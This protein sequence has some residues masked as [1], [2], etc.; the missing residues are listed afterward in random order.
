MQA[1]NNNIQ[2]FIGSPKTVFVVPVY[3]RNYDWQEENCR[4]IFADIVNVVQSGH[5]HFLGTVCFKASNSHEREIIDGQQRLTSIFLLL[6]AIHDSDFD[7][8]I[9]SEINDLYLYNKGHGIDSEF[10][11][12]KLHL[13]KRDNEIYRVILGSSGGEIDSK[14]TITQRQASVYNNYQLFCELLKEY[15]DNGGSAGDIL[16]ALRKLTFVE[17]EIQDENPQEIFES[18]NSTGLDLTNVDLL[19]NYILMQFPH[20]VQKALYEDYWSRIEDLVGSENMVCFFVDYLIFKKRSDAL[21]LNGRRSHIT[22]K[23]LYAAFKEYYAS[24]ASD[25]VYDNTRRCFEDMNNSAELYRNFI[26]SSEINLE[27]ESPLRK[28][29]YFLLVA[30]ESTKCRSLLLF[31]LDLRKRDKI[32]DVQLLDAI[33]GVASL[34]FRAKVCKAQGLNRQ[35]SGNV[36]LRLDDIQ[37]YDAFTDA[38]WR[39]MTAGKGSYAFPS[40]AEFREA[41]R[42]KD[43]YQVLRSKGTKYLLYM[44]ETR[45]PHPKGLATFDSESMTIEHIMPQKLSQEWKTYLSPLSVE[46]HEENLHRLGNLS[47]TDYNGEM[48]NK[49]FEEKKQI[50]RDSKY[51][52]TVHICD[53]E[54]WQI[55]EINDRSK[56]LADIALKIWQLPDEF[57]RN[58]AVSDSLHRL[59]EDGGQFTHTK[60]STLYMDDS[61]YKIDRWCKFLPTICKHLDNEDHGALVA[62]AKSGKISGFGIQDEDH[63]YSENESFEHISENIYI[64]AFMSAINTLET[65][66]KITR[67]FDKQAET[68]YAENVMFSIK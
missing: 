9:R 42:E 51:Y 67:E 6:K 38:Y 68:D 39:A 41:L 10:L 24:F 36:M 31:L 54:N 34:T 43:L 55:E 47:L 60:P 18:L 66:L 61:E 4:R 14:L 63:N 2:E 56:K 45:S 40:D 25:D 28:K 52:F 11:R 65:A 44:I 48:S 46:K 59:G 33:D 29:L 5:E 30:N 26:F 20:N 23:S 35:F 15:V 19:R 32:T 22:E 64:R 8:D 50:Y 58:R 12:Y 16:E 57:Q 49:T 13:N 1:H 27:K 17:L 21:L 3:Q 62:V 37:N 53:Y 7:A